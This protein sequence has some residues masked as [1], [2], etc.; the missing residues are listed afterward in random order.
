MFS[1]VPFSTESTVVR[2]GV[3]ARIYKTTFY[4]IYPSDSL[5]LSL[6]T[7][8]FLTLELFIVKKEFEAKSEAHVLNP[9]RHICRG[10]MKL[11]FYVPSI[12]L[13]LYL[14]M[15]ED[16]GVAEDF[17]FHSQRDMDS[18]SCSAS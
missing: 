1:E 18:N 10:T 6:P 9:S 16:W 12:D 5:S 7:P 13:Y 3:C 11:L 14:L 4:I 8:L 17:S 2:D 15:W